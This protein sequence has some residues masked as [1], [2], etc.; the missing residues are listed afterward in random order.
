M[1]DTFKQSNREEQGGEKQR[2]IFRIDEL[3]RARHNRHYA[4]YND[5]A[6]LP[7]LA[8][9]TLA[10]MNSA[11]HTP[12]KEAG[13]KY[14]NTTNTLGS[15]AVNYDGPVVERVTN[16]N[17]EAANETLDVNQIRQSVIEATNQTLPWSML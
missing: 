10:Q 4:L 11:S 7:A 17:P 15:Q 9:Q 12:V 16:T 13:D 5:H 3:E 14:L 6:D 8:A 1:T 2:L